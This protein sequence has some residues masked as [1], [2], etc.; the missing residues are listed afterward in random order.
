MLFW[1]VLL[2]SLSCFGLALALRFLFPTKFSTV[3]SLRLT[4]WFHQDWFW[5]AVLMLS[6]IVT[7]LPISQAGFVY[8]D[9]IIL[10]GNPCIVGPLGLKEIWTTN[11]A[12]ICPLVLSTF[13]LEHGLWG[14]N[15]T[16][17]HLVNI[18]LHGFSAVVLWRVLRQ[19]QIPGAWI[20]AALWAVHPVNV[21]SVAWI[22]EMKNTE[23]GLF[24]LLSVYFFT[25]LLRATELGGRAGCRR[26]YLLALLFAGLAIA[27]KSSAVIL[28]IALC[29][30]AW[31][32][33]GR[34]YWRNL[35]RTVPVFLMAA[36]AGA[37]SIWT[38]ALHFANVTDP[39]WVRTWPERLV[40]AGDAV[41]FYLGK[42]LFPHSLVLIYPRWQ[43]DGRH[44]VSY[45]PLL[46]A[47]LF[48][49]LFWLKRQQWSRAWFFAFGYFLLALLPALGLIDNFVF[50]YS[51]V[52]DHFQY[53][54]SM[55]PLALAGAGLA[56]LSDF[57]VS[58]N[59]AGQIALCS[60]LLLILGAA[61]W[62]RTLVYKDEKA[63]WTDTLAQ[64]PG[65]WLGEVNLGSILRDEG[66]PDEAI[67]HFQKALEIN[68]NCVVAENDL[69]VALSE[70]GQPARAIEHFQR[71]IKID[72]NFAPAR[73]NLGIV[74]LQKGQLGEAVN[75]PQ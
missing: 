63:L 21:E 37:L 53:L 38:Q 34:W 33:E 29:L 51:L 44:W 57:P 25:R 62:Q 8:D 58:K 54:A 50:E 28:P 18:L 55:G 13:W 3:S 48:L 24:F 36:A 2:L 68:P 27:S 20:G 7:Y 23:S 42:V 69:G 4:S 19:M 65:C 31:W 41:W 49:L 47:I 74:L 15:P 59:A 32:I 46:G 67:R 14:L 52:F 11:A 70:K 30:C 72:P 75:S 5:G 40:T 17:Y 9:S 60:V 61:S 43:I 6:V 56:R 16:P 12:D 1:Q 39:R 35:V 66:Q 71:A 45:L 73:N 64:N 26:S 10:T 22:T